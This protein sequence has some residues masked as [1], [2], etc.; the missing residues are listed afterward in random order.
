MLNKALLSMGVIFAVN[1]VSEQQINNPLSLEERGVGFGNLVESY[2]KGRRGYSNAIFDFLERY[3]DV[4]KTILDLGCG[5][6]LATDSLALRFREVH[7]C[8][9]DE[10]MLSIAK[11]TTNSKILYKA[12]SADQLPYENEQFGA[13]TLFT[14]F[15]WFC[16]TDAVQEIY[17]VLEPNA[18]VYIVDC[19]GV[20]F[21][22]QLIHVIE[23]AI[24]CKLISSKQ[25]FNPEEI[26][27][28]NGFKLIKKKDFE[29]MLT[30][31]VEEAIE[32]MRSMSIW[33]DVIRSG[34]EHRVIE[35]M[36]IFYKS[37][38]NP[39]DG[40]IHYQAQENMQLFKKNKICV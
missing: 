12:G 1:G 11:Q 16:N 32:R 38:A 34:K 8:D 40:L 23:D 6:G 24:E 30:F 28:K 27:M 5:T 9:I 10:E 39:K 25:N 36:R 7:G 14:S 3:V 18:F 20:P 17:R 22:D 26:L 2:I 13:I 19:S 4:N 37:K 31:T 35:D 33:N 15:H 21:G 29:V